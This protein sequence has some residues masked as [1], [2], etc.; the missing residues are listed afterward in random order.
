VDESGVV[1]WTSVGEQTS[2][3]V[4]MY[5]VLN[6]CSLEVT[7]KNAVTDMLLHN[8]QRRKIPEKIVVFTQ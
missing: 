5:A 7:C 2:T 6:Y 3:H 4:C 8:M 1:E